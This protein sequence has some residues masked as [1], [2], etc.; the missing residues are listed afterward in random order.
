[1]PAVDVSV[2]VPVRD[3]ERA[4]PTLLAALRAQTLS[5]ERFEVLVV[6]N[7]SRDRTAAVALA[8]GAR[9][10]KEPVP[11]R[12]RARNAGVASARADRIAFTDADCVPEPGW[13]AALTACLDQ[14]PLAAGPVRLTTGAQP[15]RVERL[16]AL[17]RFDQERAV[18][19]HG[20]AATANL[21]IRREAFEAVGGFDLAYRH[22]GEDVDLCLRAR[23][24]GF[25][26]A[27]CPG[28][29]VA[30]AAERTLRPLMRRAFID[31]W[32]T[33]QHHRRLRGE[34][35]WEYWRH[36][37]PMVA[38]DWAL[39]RFGNAAATERDLL[40]LA[41]ADYAARWAGS[42]WGV[43]RGVR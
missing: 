12:G 16:E 9:V 1:V 15:S 18:R 28:A 11:G 34:T 27:Y 7:A 17:W 41:R 35:G 10:V 6:D 37:R 30:H 42:L 33:L 29:G 43:V 8:H 32:S 23:R 2:V 25:R 31:G 3:G 19:E 36:P 20:W 38:G 24:A 39:R 4:L 13:L 21:G 26:L 14:S 22:I 40:P 5:S